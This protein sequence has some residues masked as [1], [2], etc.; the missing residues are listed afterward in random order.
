MCREKATTSW[1]DNDMMTRML[2]ASSMLELIALGMIDSVHR[3]HVEGNT[4]AW[5][6]VNKLDELW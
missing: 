1:R 4:D 3:M 2:D 5:P 6:N